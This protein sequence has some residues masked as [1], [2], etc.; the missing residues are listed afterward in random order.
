MNATDQQF[1]T[2]QEC[3]AQRKTHKYNES[4]HLCSGIVPT[5]QRP[6]EIIRV[7]PT[8]WYERLPDTLRD[9]ES[10]LEYTKALAN[11]SRKEGMSLDEFQVTFHQGKIFI[12]SRNLIRGA[13]PSNRKFRWPLSHWSFGQLCSLVG[14]PAAF[15]RTLPGLLVA[16]ILNVKLR[17]RNKDISVYRVT[18]EVDR[19]PLDEV[20][21]L[22]SPRY[23]RIHDHT[24]LEWVQANSDEVSWVHTND[25]GFEVSIHGPRVRA[26]DEGTVRLSLV[27]GNSEVGASSVTTRAALVH[28][29][30]RIPVTLA[31]ARVRHIG[32]IQAKTFEKL[33]DAWLAFRRANVEDLEEQIVAA[34][35]I[36]T[37]SRGEWLSWL[38]SRKVGRNLANKIL[39]AGGENVSVS[40]YTLA[41]R[42]ARRAQEIPYFNE[43]MEAELVAPKVLGI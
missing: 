2:P 17:Q 33:N 42:L 39:P 26:P 32:D 20:R 27:V 1:L 38:K 19:L 7:L 13:S 36:E 3:S 30:W 40:R 9:M 24:I 31:G 41:V 8:P 11:A 28:S 18:Q 37:K 23:S 29:G 16:E 6:V 10:A 35:G 15:L 21:A 22:T 34:H 25:R 12:E 4:C 43:R 5:P 14:A